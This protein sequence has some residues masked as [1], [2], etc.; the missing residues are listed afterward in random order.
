MWNGTPPRS[1]RGRRAD[2]SDA[3]FRRPGPNRPPARPRPGGTAS[4]PRNPYRPYRDASRS[5]LPALRAAPG[6][7]GSFGRNPYA[8][9]E[10]SYGFTAAELEAATGQHTGLSLFH[11]GNPGHLWRGQVTGL[12]GETML[13]AGTLMWLINLTQSPL[14]IALSVAAIGLPFVLAGPLAAPLEYVED[15]GSPLKWLGRLR[16]LLALGLIAMY[17]Q[18]IL[19][20]VYALLFG[21]SLLGRL[22]EGLYTAATRTCLAPGEPEIV[23]NDSHI[24]GAIAAVVGPLLAT[25][26][27]I[28][29]GERI[30]LVSAVSAVFFLISMNGLSFLDALPPQRRAFLLVTPATAMLNGEPVAMP[31]EEDDEEPAGLHERD[32]ETPETRREYGLPEWYQ[33]GPVTPFQALADVRAGLGLAGSNRSSSVGMW[34]LSAL[35]LTGGGLAALEVFYITNAILLPSFYLGPLLATEAAGLS[36]GLLIANGLL[37][38]GAWRIAMFAG[39]VGSGIALAALAYFPIIVIAL[40]LALALGVANALAVAGARHALLAGF[41]GIERRALSA[42]ERLVTASCGVAG[43]LLF[44]VFYRGASALPPQIHLPLNP[45]PWP[46]GVVLV[47]AGI[48][49]AISSVPFALQLKAKQKRRKDDTASGPTTGRVPG[50]LPALGGNT[51]ASGL[52]AALDDEDAD[53]AG[54]WDDTD[55]GDGSWDEG[56]D[57]EDYDGTYGYDDDAYDDA[58]DDDEDDDP[59][60]R[61][62]ARRPQPRNDRDRRLRW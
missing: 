7:L 57:R 11:D 43:A 9:P 29:L 37:A 30:L 24:G 31:A 12:L 17:F 55:E 22:Q 62:G 25:L 40:A 36:I 23:A 46:V 16:I 32:E 13:N 4:D 51:T 58:P 47:L 18:T 14:A 2:D 3:S 10:D 1:P 20:V 5:N 49:L 61:R 59:R 41:D 28:L 21:V 42:A 35:A 60:G 26:F 15:P 54:A 33:Q 53:E 38:H 44:T 6:T 56:D 39:L 52:I 48:S 8:Q 50:V 45:Q 19:P 34:V 27:F